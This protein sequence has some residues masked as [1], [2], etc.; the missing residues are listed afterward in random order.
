M[1]KDMTHQ[2]RHWNELSIVC[3]LVVWL[4]LLG[5]GRQFA[6][7]LRHIIGELLGRFSF[8]LSG[9]GSLELASSVGLEEWAQAVAPLILLALLCLLV[10][11][12]KPPH[13]QSGRTVTPGPERRLPV[14][15]RD[16]RAAFDAWSPASL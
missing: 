4:C 2:T 8:R 3:G 12:E 11:R 6:R 5:V 16:V 15:K 14:Q 10:E 7:S 1:S 9:Q 13:H